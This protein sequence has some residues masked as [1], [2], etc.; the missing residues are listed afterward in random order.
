MPTWRA[1]SAAVSA[2]VAGDHVDPDARVVAERDGAG[3]SGR[4]GSSSATRPRQPQVTLERTRGRRRRPRRPSVAVG[5]REHAQPTA[6]RD[7]APRLATARASVV[8]HRHARPARQHRAWPAPGPPLARPSRAAA[9][10]PAP[11]STV[12]ISRS[13]ELE[14]EEVPASRDRAPSGRRAG[15]ALARPP[16]RRARSGPRRPPPSSGPLGPSRS[17][18]S[19]SANSARRVVGGLRHQRHVAAG[20]PPA[21][22][23]MRLAVRVPVLSVQ[24]TVV[25]PSVS[26]AESRLTTAP[27][28]ATTRTPT[29]SARVMVGSSPRARSPRAAR[30]RTGR[31]P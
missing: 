22:G 12:D 10:R 17:A 9:A 24:M 28:R 18:A 3:T 14:R 21:T 26:T 7:R 30:R 4:G 13:A 20:D 19:A 16:S 6:A 31:R 2:V 29:A 15:R 23:C 1:T 8:V 25:D 5:D 11:A 27:R